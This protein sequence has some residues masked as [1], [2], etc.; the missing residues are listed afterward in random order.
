V[1]G[2]R[3][4]LAVERMVVDDQN[5]QSIVEDCVRQ[6]PRG[7]LRHRVAGVDGLNG[8]PNIKA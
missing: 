1:D 5:F 3:C 8:Q 4:H 6:M 7:C 2:G